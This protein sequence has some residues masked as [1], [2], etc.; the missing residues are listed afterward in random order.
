MQARGRTPALAET[1]CQG[2]S[3]NIADI[4]GAAL[5]P[6]DLPAWRW[7]SLPALRVSRSGKPP[8]PQLRGAM[9]L[10]IQVLCGV[11]WCGVRVE[12]VVATAVHGLGAPP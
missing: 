6:Y 8:A 10:V 11:A 2:A 1:G 7:T 5:L 9:E 3:W 12:R 4:N